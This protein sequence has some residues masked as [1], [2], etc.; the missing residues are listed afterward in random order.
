MPFYDTLKGNKKFEWT[1]ECEKA[2]QQL[3]HYLATPPV[4]AK[5]LEGERLFLYIAVSVTAVRGVLI[6]EERSEQKP[7]FYVSK[8][9]LDAE[10]RYPM[11]EKLALAVVMSAR[12]LRPYFQSH[13]VIVLTSF[14]L[15]TI[16][17][18]PSQ[19]GRLAKLAIELSE[20]DI[21]YRAKSCAKSQVLADF[22]VELPTG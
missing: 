20:Y 6:R 4:L 10:T 1:E 8:T 3:K 9:L 11:M 21:E 14:P 15:R 16:L 13:T 17:H 7:I 5:P 19:S 12:K 18:S 22:L 2:F